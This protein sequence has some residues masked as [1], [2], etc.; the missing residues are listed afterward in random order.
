MGGRAAI[1][2]NK[3]GGAGK[4]SCKGSQKDKEVESFGNSSAYG[5]DRGQWILVTPKRGGEQC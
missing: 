2:G 5:P 4:G 3:T 1:R